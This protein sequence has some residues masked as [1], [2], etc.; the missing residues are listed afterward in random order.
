MFFERKNVEIPE[1]S[2]T[3]C[4]YRIYGIGKSYVGMSKDPLRRFEEHLRF[5]TFAS[6]LP[7][8]FRR[9][10]YNPLLFRRLKYN[11]LLLPKDFRRVNYT[12]LL[13]RRVKYTPLF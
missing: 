1:P 9:L 6:R 4:I 13:F 7:K 3:W 12:P 2:E 11:P 5:A 8:D 10:K